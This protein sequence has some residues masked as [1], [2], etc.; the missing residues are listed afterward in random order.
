MPSLLE[1]GTPVATPKRVR[2]ARSL[3]FT[4]LGGAAAVASVGAGI[5]GA[6]QAEGGGDDEKSDAPP[7][8]EEEEEHEEE[9]EEDEEP[10]EKKDTV[11]G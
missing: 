9:N 6:Q 11:S 3:A 2:V 1:V 10:E 8:A 7:P 5:L 4:S